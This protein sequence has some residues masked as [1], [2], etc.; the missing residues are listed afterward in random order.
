MERKFVIVC[1]PLSN[2][3]EYGRLRKCEIQPTSKIGI[4]ILGSSIYRRL[5]GGLEN[6]KESNEGD[7]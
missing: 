4:K 2:T 3:Y 6:R 1:I 5:D 7:G